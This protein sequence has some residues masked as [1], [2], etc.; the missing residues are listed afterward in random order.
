MEHVP[1]WAI[2]PL[3]AG[4]YY[5]PQFRDDREWYCSTLF[6]GESEM[7]TKHNCYSRPTWPLGS[8]FSD[9]PFAR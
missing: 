5:K 1:A 6:H 9:K 4:R 2:K 7:A 8:G 3:D